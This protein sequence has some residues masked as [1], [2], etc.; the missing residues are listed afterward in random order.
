MRNK[1]S[2]Y[3]ILLIVI[4]FLIVLI[5]SLLM[6]VNPTHKI[7]H[8]PM[9]PTENTTG[10]RLNTVFRKDGELRFL[11][12]RS[13]EII[14]TIDIEL[15]D[16]DAEREQGLMYR[17]SMNENEGMLF[18]M[19]SEEIQSFWMKNTIISLDIIYADSD[20][21][22]VSIHKNCKPYSLDNITSLRPA[23]YVVEV[24]AGYCERHSLTAG[25]MI[26]F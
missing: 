14:S 10:N 12:K 20:R 2:I 4:L 23:L 22:I 5:G 1:L 19:E 11:Q 7:Q 24:N 9:I 16:T 15:A 6:F 25:D 17:E 8:K 26:S 13:D 3:K 18:L 21:H